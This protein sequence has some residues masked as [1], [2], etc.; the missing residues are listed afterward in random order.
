MAPSHKPEIMLPAPIPVD[1]EHPSTLKGVPDEQIQLSKEFSSGNPGGMIGIAA[2]WSEQ[3]GEG[4]NLYVVPSGRPFIGAL[5]LAIFNFPELPELIMVCLVDFIQ[6]PCHEAGDIV[7]RVP[8]RSGE[9]TQMPISIPNLSEG[10]HD[11]VIVLWD[12]NKAQPKSPHDPARERVT[13]KAFRTSIAVNGYTAPQS[14]TEQPLPWPY[15]VFGLE[16]LAISQAKDIWDDYGTF[17][18]I[19]NLQVKPGQDVEFYLHVFNR[20]QVRVE[21]AVAAFI[22]YRQVPLIYESNKLM[23]MHYSAKAGGWYPIP[24]QIRAPLEPGGYEFVVIGEHFPGA[25]MDLES[26]LYK[27]LETLSLDVWS[28]AQIYLEV[29]E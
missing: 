12:D 25:R 22:D 4:G 1:V 28:S 19:T 16:G 15:H 9:L 14:V 29:T 21:W 26:S 6:T 24:V 7:Q 8:L 13:Q 27:D 17:D 3:S 11:L 23:P 2:T 5:E 18:P 20:Q 10:L